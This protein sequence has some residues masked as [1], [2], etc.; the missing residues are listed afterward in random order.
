MWLWPL[1]PDG[2]LTFVLSLSERGIDESTTTIDAAK[3]L[4]AAAH[5]ENL[6]ESDP[7]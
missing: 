7:G 5:A 3:I 4:T 6:W 2:P 1:P